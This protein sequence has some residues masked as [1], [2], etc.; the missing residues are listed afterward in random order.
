MTDMIPQS[1]ALPSP[2]IV[3]VVERIP[4]RPDYWSAE[5]AF[6]AGQAYDQAAGANAHVADGYI[7]HAAFFREQDEDGCTLLLLYPWRDRDAASRLLDSEDTLLSVWFAT[8]A[9]GP[10]RVA[11][12][13][14]LAVDVDDH[15]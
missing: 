8:Y 4:L 7:G 10:R 11:F 14:E 3:T 6:A 12:L 15:A 2:P 9:A 5:G 13:D 1:P